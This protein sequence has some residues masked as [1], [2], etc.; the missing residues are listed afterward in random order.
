MTSPND[1]RW[2][3]YV[4]I[5]NENFTN[6]WKDFL[7]NNRKIFYLL[8]C[9][10]DSRMCTILKKLLENNSNSDFSYRAID[11]DEGNAS[12]SHNHSDLKDNN[13]NLL[14]EI[15]DDSELDIVPLRIRDNA[16]NI[17][18]RKIPELVPS[19][20]DIVK[21]TDIVVDIS[22]LPL[23]IYFPL[24]AKILDMLDNEKK[25]NPRSKLPN[26]HVVVTEN[27]KIDALIEQKEL[28][29]RAM[30]VYPFQSNLESE[31]P[32]KTPR[33]WIP[34]L[35]ENQDLQL[36][37]ISTLVRPD[38]IN[39]IFPAVASNPRRGDDIYLQHINT[40]KRLAIDYQNITYGSEKN[41]FE[42]YRGIF[43]T[44]KRYR[45][46]FDSL[47]PCKISLSSLS[48]KLLSMATF[49]TAYEAKQNELQVAIS[50]VFSRG[51]SINDEIPDSIQS[52]NE[53]FSLWVFGECYEL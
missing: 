18:I 11:Y 20:D 17:Q 28:D 50:Q 51:F 23:Y 22:A 46:S 53:L 44:I 36:Q 34:I 26:L 48:S 19:I 29:E 25:R 37:K 1:S 24:V 14:K 7:K 49:F 27:A 13:I 52:D 32:R 3:D 40:F 2:N 9:G 5:D 15:T 30:F 12:P 45:E 47:G 33:I 6:F 21:F 42:V 41:P 10:F 35:G 16:N 43:S 4:I 38:E 39:P 31:D 8:G